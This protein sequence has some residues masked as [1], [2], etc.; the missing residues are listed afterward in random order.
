MSWSTRALISR[1]AMSEATIER[2]EP[3][4]AHP[5]ESLRGVFAPERFPTEQQY[6]TGAQALERQSFARVW[7]IYYRSGGLLVTGV[8]VTPPELKA[9]SHPFIVFNRGGNRRFGM[10]TAPFIF[11]ALLPLSRRNNALVFASNYRGVDGGEGQ[12]EMGGADIED[13]LALCRIACAHPAWNGIHSLMFGISRGGSMTFQAL[14]EHAPVHAAAVIAGPT[15]FWQA[16]QER[17]EMV[18]E[19]EATMPDYAVRREEHFEGRSAIR[20][21]QALAR[22]LLLLH[23]DADWRVPVTHSIRLSEAMT[24]CGRPHQLVVYPRDDHGLSYN[25]E[26]ALMRIGDWLHRFTGA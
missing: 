17:P 3:F 10:L 14:K 4:V 5:Y 23:G 6:L 16:E 9:K 12:D 26:D 19:Y 11:R 22:P 24:V 13:V 20:W 25:W 18:L 8:L 2:Q 21:P 1:S 15:D 7:R